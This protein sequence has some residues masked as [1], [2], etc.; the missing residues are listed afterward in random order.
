[1]FSLTQFQTERI[2]LR[3]PLR[4]LSQVLMTTQVAQNDVGVIAEDSTLTVAKW[5]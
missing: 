3:Q 5:R 2:Q 4:S 1:M